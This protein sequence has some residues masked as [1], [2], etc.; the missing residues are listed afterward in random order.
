MQSRHF[1]E[2][3]PGLS[4]AL[5]SCQELCQLLLLVQQGRHMGHQLQLLTSMRMYLL[6]GETQEW[7]NRAHVLQMQVCLAVRLQQM[8]VQ[9]SWVRFSH[10]HLQNYGTCY[11]LLQQCLVVA[12]QEL[13]HQGH[14]LRPEFG[15]QH[16]PG[17]Q[18]QS[19]VLTSAE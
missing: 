8:Q 7:R 2:L 11:L 13:M 19:Q 4:G 18:Q 12:L 16:L 3:S 6:A 10:R 17:L 15:P 5:R 9:Q 1:L 14:S